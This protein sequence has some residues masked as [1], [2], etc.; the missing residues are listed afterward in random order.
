MQLY[1]ILSILI[2]VCLFASLVGC[3]PASTESEKS[4]TTTEAT[5]TETE[6]SDASDKED[7][8]KRPSPH[9]I[10]AD[11][12]SNAVVTVNYG[13]PGVKGR[14]VW[15]ELVPYGK[16]WR[17]G[18]DEATTVSFDRDVMIEGQALKAGRYAF[19]TIPEPD[20]WTVIFNKEADQWGAF[21]Y[22]QDQDALRAKIA[23]KQSE[24]TE[25]LTFV[26][27]GETLN[28]NW[29]NLSLPIRISTAE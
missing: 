12:I 9:L 15:G 28:L 6:T 8:T 1:R 17:T 19:F 5:P 22:H 18:A 24:L 10:V 27:N 23:P 3:Q 13:S 29:A 11:T 14:K 26:G 2:S 20:V 4:E 7:K 21:E 25:R 16:V